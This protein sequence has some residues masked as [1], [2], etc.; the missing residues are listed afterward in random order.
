MRKL[1]KNREG[2]K[3]PTIVEVQD[4][5]AEEIEDAEVIEVES[6]EKI[7]ESVD[8][9][10]EVIAE[11]VLK[12][13]KSACL[14][15]SYKSRGGKTSIELETGDFELAVIIKDNDSWGL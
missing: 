11:N 12:L 8:K 6:Q 10:F 9:A 2:E 13:P 3:L 15:R 1:S 7:S 14:L 5:L 4:R